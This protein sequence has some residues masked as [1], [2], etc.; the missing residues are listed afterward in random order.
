MMKSRIQLGLLISA[1]FLA[2]C[3]AI[4]GELI[5]GDDEVLF[6]WLQGVKQWDFSS[7]LPQ[8][9]TYYRPLTLFSYFF[10]QLFWQLNPMVMHLENIILHCINA[11]LVFFIVREFLLVEERQ[12]SFLPLAAALLFALHPLTTESVNWISGRTDL[13]AGVFILLSTLAL[14]HFRKQRHSMDLFL[15]MSLFTLGVL[16]KEVSAAF[17]AGAFYI[18]LVRPQNLSIPLSSVQSEGEWRRWIYVSLSGLIVS[19]FFIRT[20]VQIWSSGKIGLTLKV[21]SAD[22]WYSLF[23]CLRA[24][25]F[26]IKKIVWPLPLNFVILEVDPL[27]ELLAIPLLVF[28]LYLL[29]KR[30]TANALILTGIFLIT[31]A[32]LIAFNQISWTPYAERYL[33]LPCA[34]IVPG[35][36]LLLAKKF[37][38]QY[39]GIFL[40]IVALVAVGMGGVTFSR[41]ITWRS[42]LALWEDS[43]QKSPLS[44]SALNEYGLALYRTGRLVEAKDKFGKASKMTDSNYNPT[45]GINYALVLIELNDLWGA[46]EAFERVLKKTQGKSTKAR[47]GLIEVMEKLLSQTDRHDTKSQLETE[48]ITLKSQ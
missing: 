47:S 8:G 13:L 22:L 35:I 30:S 19:I 39:S 6:A 28:C 17:L 4:S 31:P 25:A 18:V 26:Y 37:L 3:P 43:V 29:W 21:I 36:L 45:H 9:G 2:F 23:V 24:F 11:C 7:F 38:P 46:K 44:A 5:T 14:I 15:A 27:Y 40:V 12:S 16:S 33:Y 48:L 42:N 41:S 20:I 1:I 34:F 10:D 32:F